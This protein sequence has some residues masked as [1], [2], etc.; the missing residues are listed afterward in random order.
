MGIPSYYRHLIEKYSRLVKRDHKFS[1]KKKNLYFD[2]NAL[3][4]PVVQKVVSENK[5]SE[6]KIRRYDQIENKILD[7]V[8]NYTHEI[9]QKINPDFTLIAIDG[10][11]PRFKMVQQR[12]RRFKSILDKK[13][14]CNRRKNDSSFD[15]DLEYIFDRNAISPGTLFMKKLSERINKYINETKQNIILMDDTHYGEGEHR[16]IDYIKKYYNNES[17]LT[18]IIYSLD[19]D[20]IILGLSLM[21]ENVYLLREKQ[22]F[23]KKNETLEENKE[24]FLYLDINSLSESLWCEIKNQIERYVSKENYIYDYIFLC[25][26][27][28]NDFIPHL[29]EMSLHDNGLDLL[30]KNYTRNIFKHQTKLYNYGDDS[31]NQ[32]FLI[33]IF[34]DILVHEEKL[35]FDNSNKRDKEIIGY[36]IHKNWK[37]NHYNYFFRN[38]DSYNIERYCKEYWK[39]FIW[40]LKY[41]RKNTPE[42]WRFYYRWKYSPTL[43]DL[44]VFLKHNDLKKIIKFHK[45]SP[46]TPDQQL[47]MI[48][49][50]ESMGL[51]KEKY[52]N[53]PKRELRQYFPDRYRLEK[54]NRPIPW[55]YEPILSNIDDRKIER[56]V[57]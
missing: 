24:D 12:F 34:S 21:K 9:I 2:Y 11:V 7:E 30:L 20:I 33:D 13:I 5:K 49:P 46:Y 31:F 27:M 22:Y 48:L 8:I 41:Y 39:T 37:M 3:I 17:D 43:S 54:V 15:P 29:K 16:I 28:G 57:N 35:V 26:F 55:M 50:K 19:A 44:V 6:N 52:R 38:T 53:L 47:M 4:H 51:V 42:S 23:E 40:T 36:G 1:T 14:E 18:H 45:D 56:Y 10:V 32:D 25:F